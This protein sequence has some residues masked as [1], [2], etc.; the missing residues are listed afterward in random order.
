MPLHGAQRSDR[1]R[2]KTT[3]T[4][5]QD[6]TARALVKDHSSTATK[7]YAAE[8]ARAPTAPVIFAVLLESQGDLP[9]IKSGQGCE[10][11]NFRWSGPTVEK[12][13]IKSI[14][15][16]STICPCN[17]VWYFGGGRSRHCQPGQ[18]RRTRPLPLQSCARHCLKRLCRALVSKLR[19]W[20]PSPGFPPLT[21][22]VQAPKSATMHR[23]RQ[24]LFS[25]GRSLDMEFA[26]ENLTG[27]L[28]SERAR[29]R[30]DAA[31][32]PRICRW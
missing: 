2:S 12:L 25:Y 18:T 1:P 5:Q 23:R 7:P 32:V 20:R 3:K 17:R 6:P 8:P 30:D 9:K 11:S 19:I 24:V 10:D 29:P 26:V 14:R 4:K 15:R 22:S 31:P 28:R 27:K 13:H 16:T 21:Y